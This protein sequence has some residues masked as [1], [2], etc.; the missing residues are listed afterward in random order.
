MER[1]FEGVQEKGWSKMPT[2]VRT[3]FKL[4]RGSYAG[5]IGKVNLVADAGMFADGLKKIFDPTEE[6]RALIDSAA[7]EQYASLADAENQA[8]WNG[9]MQ[10]A[11][12]AVDN[13]VQV[14]AMNGIA[15]G[16]QFLLSRL[17][18]AGLVAALGGPVGIIASIVIFAALDRLMQGE[19]APEISGSA[20]ETLKNIEG[21]APLAAT[22]ATTLI[23]GLAGP[24]VMPAI[25]SINWSDVS[26]NSPADVSALKRERNSERFTTGTMLNDNGEE[27]SATF[28]DYS[29]GFGRRA[30]EVEAL[31]SLGYFMTAP[32]DAEGKPLYTT[33]VHPGTGQTV[34]YREYVFNGGAFQDW[35]ENSDWTFG[36]ATPTERAFEL[37]RLDDFTV[38]DLAARA[39]TREEMNAA[40]NGYYDLIKG[41]VGLKRK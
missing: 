5:A 2:P 11:G 10:I 18:G 12:L 37:P 22:P 29:N 15:K 14:S 36:K 9:A 21:A 24:Y 17:G 19:R 20:Y 31:L 40:M 38:K 28:I 16:T 23:G 1:G 7:S 26:K 25:R 13:I 41:D 6:A 32:M 35:F 33:W 27:V 8:R 3:A 4:T 34:K 39:M 30:D